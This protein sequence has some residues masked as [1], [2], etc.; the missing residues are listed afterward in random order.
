MRFW[1]RM[2]VQHVAPA[3]GGAS[4]GSKGSR[5]APH[6]ESVVVLGFEL[7]VE[8]VDVELADLDAVNTILLP[9]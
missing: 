3:G 4:V 6:S 5:V 8:L 1:R 9:G 7:A 2:K